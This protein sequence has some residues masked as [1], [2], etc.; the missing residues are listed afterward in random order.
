[1][2]NR[3]YYDEEDEDQG[4]NPYAAVR[5]PIVL[6]DKLGG[7]DFVLA[8][9]LAAFAFAF[10]FLFAL[11]GLYPSAWS[12]LSVAA[13]LRPAE[14][15]FPGLWR[16]IGRAI[17]LGLGTSMANMAMP[18]IGKV[19]LAIDTFL[20]YYVLRGM[21]AVLVRL[22]KDN[23]VWSRKLARLVTAIG[24][25][26]FVC[27]DPVWRVSQTFEPTS[28]ILFLTILAAYLLTRFLRSGHMP[29]A[30]LAMLVLGLL[31]AETPFGFALLAGF[32]G[33]YFILLA[34]GHL[35]YM[36]MLHPFVGQISKWYLTFIWAFGLLLGIA[37]NVLGY[38]GMKGLEANGVAVGDLPANYITHMWQT[39]IQA[40][41]AGGWILG[42]G[43]VLLPLMLSFM[44]IRRAT[45][46]EY[47]LPY[48]TGV[49][50]FFTGVFA[51]SQLA[52]LAP[53][54]FWTWIKHPVMVPSVYLQC[55]F[56]MVCTCTLVCTLAVMA[57]DAYCRNHRRLAMQYNPEAAADKE[58]IDELGSARLTSIL[59]KIGVTF[60][61]A[62]LVAGLLPGR[63]QRTTRAMLAM[64]RDYV[65]E[66]V[67][68]CEGAKWLFTDGAYDCIV[69]LEAAAQGRELHCLSMMS[70][71]TP[72]N[73]FIRK[74]SLQ[75]AEDRLSATVGAPNILRTWQRDKKDR[76]PMCGLQLGLELWKR[77]GLEVPPCSG[78]VSRPEG[79]P[80]ER[81]EEGV[82]EGYLLTERV[83]AL[84]AAGGGLPAIAG[85]L[86]NDL[87][88]FMQWRL[89][90]LARLRA[91]RYDHEGKT[92]RSLEE[93]RI[94]DS[95]DDKNESLKRILEGMARL[96]EL[97]MRQM[98][99]REGLQFA[100]V[101]AD[102][103]LA[104][105][106]AE[107][108][109]DADPDDP[110]ANFGMGMSYFMQEQFGRAEEYL[111]RCL[112]KNDQEPAVWN[113][114]AVLQLRTGRFDEAMKNAKKALSLIPDSAEVKDTISQIEKAM[115]AAKT[116][117]A[118][119][120]SAP[121]KTEPTKK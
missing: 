17:Y 13:G 36:V 85:P 66:T 112:K 113:N 47:F 68:E 40:A 43:V 97:T 67:R 14:A 110:N 103:S 64:M 12:D 90:R 48:H 37:G 114:I 55:M 104:R 106:Y 63:I 20:M 34:K 26:A 27:A 73:A 57:V 82:K 2:K 35:Q 91:E 28:L 79:V 96:R 24:V 98:T 1:M 41:S 59:R 77:A 53:L 21:L 94:S 23:V 54:W 51:Y 89:A 109:L 42:A 39:F 19:F 80:P 16:L 70:A 46:E 11:P 100:L 50:F 33:V 99:P 15:I 95:L 69:E 29:A 49:I 7:G 58:A 71:N 93:I 72:R 116:N 111:M 115:E 102:F 107:P 92:A 44:M 87:F 22:R 120:A 8:A 88:L 45:D 6:P 74:E 78:A 38:M 105:K 52:S 31:C 108:I 9:I 86:V 32:W 121:A 3:D 83:L 5:Q 76:L 30:Y 60:V 101:R 10:A 61:P 56:S 81:I 65:Q 25:I 75:D 118:A 117:T 84:Y 4:L 119:K 62:L 18:I